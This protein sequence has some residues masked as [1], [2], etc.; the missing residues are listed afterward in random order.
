MQLK[1][2]IILH[3]LVKFTISYL[4]EN[5]KMPKK[6]ENLLNGENCKHD[7]AYYTSVILHYKS[8]LHFGFVIYT[9]LDKGLVVCYRL[10]ISF[11]TLLLCDKDEIRLTKCMNAC[12]LNTLHMFNTTLPTLF[13]LRYAAAFCR[14]GN[15]KVL[16][17]L[18]VPHEKEL[19]FFMVY[20]QWNF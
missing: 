1:N 13:S 15:N 8:F 18:C 12:G 9:R 10:A 16:K 17:I 14:R 4:L 5:I 6:L 11:V 7:K 20:R 3:L 2:I 19:T